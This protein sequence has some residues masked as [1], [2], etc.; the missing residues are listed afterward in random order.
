MRG[1]LLRAYAW[2]IGYRFAELLKGTLSI[3]DYY[4]EL[5]VDQIRSKAGASLSSAGV[6]LGFSIAVLAAVVASDKYRQA[7]Q[8]VL[9]EHWRGRAMDSLAVLVLLYSVIRQERI[10]S[11][12]GKKT[13]RYVALFCL[14][15]VAF[16][17]FLT[18]P[19]NFQPEN[20]VVGS[21]VSSAKLEP[22]F[23]LSGF[24]SIIVS[25]FF[26]VFALE[27]YDSAS[28]WRGGEKE[29]G[30]ALRFHLAGIA[31]HSFIFG[32]SFAILGVSLLFSL[33]DFKAGSI[34]TLIGLLLLVAVTEIERELWARKERD[35]ECKPC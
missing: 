31:S 18:G 9:R 33:A 25:I 29:G 21:L 30:R 24:L 34:I 22:A 35:S 27:F 8:S 1:A 23:L 15:A 5:K 28:G 19:L 7:L 16:L 3:P 13:W 20:P 11:R 26:E 14:L 32:V 12:E 17:L 6:I 4:K 2:L 10:L